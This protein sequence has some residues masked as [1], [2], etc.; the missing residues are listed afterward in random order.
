LQLDITY[1]YYFWNEEFSHAI[2][3]DIMFS[4]IVTLEIEDLKL[5][6]QL[7]LPRG[8][9]LYT[10]VCICHGIPAKEPAPDD[11]GYPLL[12]EKICHQGFA[13]FVFN[14]RGTGD[15]GGNLDILGWTRDLKTVID[16]LC[17]LSEVDRSSLSLLGFS[18]GAAV[19]IYVAAQDRRVSSI[20]ACASPAEFTFFTEVDDLQSVVGYFRDLGTIRDKDFPRSAQEWFDGFSLVSP[21]KHVAEITP[22]PILL[23]HGNKDDMVD[24]SHARKL[25]DRAKEPKRLVIIEGAGHR[26]RQ[27]DEAMAII[28]D[29][30]K[31]QV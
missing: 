28:I 4:R 21:I 29:W 3:V 27:N 19:S 2:T 18:A 25:Y 20:A 22:R 9:P 13:T 10:A 1:P 23:V 17:A 7:Y 8:K 12:A 24:V 31:S 6:G 14:F 30:L 5:A 16:Y 11:G 15:S 26:L